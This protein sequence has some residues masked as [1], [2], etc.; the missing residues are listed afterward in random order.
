MLLP[1][2]SRGLNSSM[3]YR[4]VRMTSNYPTSCLEV[5]RKQKVNKPI[6]KGAPG[7]SSV[8]T[9]ILI[10]LYSLVAHVC[11]KKIS[12]SYNYT[13]IVRYAVYKA[14]NLHKCQLTLHDAIVSHHQN[15]W[16]VTF[17]P[18]SCLQ[19]NVHKMICMTRNWKASLCVSCGY[20]QKNHGVRRDSSEVIM[21]RHHA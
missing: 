11:R 17:K 7:K 13:I 16:I 1:V 8:S 3:I 6:F 21:T 19:Y 18:W 12:L 14:W 15:G 9:N 20:Y 5:R 4:S 10:T 2:L